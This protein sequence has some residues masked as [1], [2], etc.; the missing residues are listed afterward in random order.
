MAGGIMS[1]TP[2]R[3]KQAARLKV[4]SAY[5]D[6]SDG[7]PTVLIEPEDIEEHTA[8]SRQDVSAATE[9][10]ISQGLV[11]PRAL[12]GVASISHAGV[13][14]VERA[15]AEPDR[16]TEHFPSFVINQVF[17]APV[18]AVQT[19]A[20]STATINQNVGI[21]AQHLA[22][23]IA[24]LRAAIPR[25]RTELHEAVDD[26]QEEVSSPSP[27]TSR[28]RSSLAFLWNA[29]TGIATIG[30]FVVPLAQ[31]YGIQLPGITPGA[32]L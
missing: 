29:A 12:G 17:H 31:A 28:I 27:K 3:E 2:L 25:E 24:S 21:D 13:V 7:D 11:E 4:L 10:L 16:P 20:R 5:Y 23:L 14:E 22:A 9:Y 18:G 15:Q 30:Q 1:P 8:L 32:G 6:L 26:L 19:G